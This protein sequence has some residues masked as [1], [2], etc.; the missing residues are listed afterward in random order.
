[1]SDA[2]GFGEPIDH[3]GL[4]LDEGL[5]DTDGVSRRTFVQLLGAG[6]LLTVTDR[7]AFG[8]RGR[9]S[10]FGEGGPATIAVRLHLGHDGTI[11][12]LTGK[13]EL[14]QGARTELTQAAAEELR[15]GEDQIHL[16]M[17]DTALVPSDGI[18][19]GSQ[20]TP[21]TVPAVR[22]A[23][24]AARELLV[25]L[26]CQR[27]QADRSAVEVR[28][29]GVITHLANKQTLSYADLAQDAEVAKLLGQAIPADIALTPVE[30]W[31]ILGTAVPRPN[32][33]DLVT[34]TH[35]YPSDIVR[36][37]M[38]YGKVLCPARSRARR[39]ARHLCA[40]VPTVPWRPRPIILRGN[41]LWT[42]WPR[43]PAPI[44][45]RSGSP[46]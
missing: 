29:R 44:R 13:V 34:G 35:R 9:P 39:A 15:V 3:E 37:G 46:A 41:R 40:R 26:A 33:R 4:E 21:R 10:G 27:W 2:S 28:E 32:R 18:T 19:A 7:A 42:S 36:P 6:L 30:Q 43:P 23:A 1:M 31:K 5:G 38:L 20:T 45:W 17:A 16:I 12:V 11:T 24:A 14:G 25:R 22:R 8:Q